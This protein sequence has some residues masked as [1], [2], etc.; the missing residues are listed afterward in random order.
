MH[1]LNYL[2]IGITCLCKEQLDCRLLTCVKLLMFSV[3]L[4]VFSPTFSTSTNEM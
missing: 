1:T 2:D 4:G 3:D